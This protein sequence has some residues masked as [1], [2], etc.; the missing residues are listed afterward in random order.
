MTDATTDDIALQAANTLA[1]DM[2]DAILDIFKTEPLSWK[3]TNAENQRGIANRV[4]RVVEDVIRRACII[5]YRQNLVTIDASLAQAVRKDEKIEL[6]INMPGNH[7]GRHDV[8]DAV[9]QI[10]MLVVGAD[11]SNYMDHRPA[12]VDPDEPGLPL[13]PDEGS[14]FDRTPNGRE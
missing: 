13:E 6:K 3:M 9:G 5:I 11:A 2:R 1:P 8:I 12:E 14:V 10:V 7:P 4:D